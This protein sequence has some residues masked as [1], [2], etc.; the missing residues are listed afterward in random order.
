MGTS[1]LDFP[2]TMV[3]CP[4]P[5]L[6]PESGV[7]FFRL[8]LA[9]PLSAADWRLEAEDVKDFEGLWGSIRWEET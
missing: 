7:L 3:G 4:F 8:L 2:L 5:L 6:I 1:S 9:M